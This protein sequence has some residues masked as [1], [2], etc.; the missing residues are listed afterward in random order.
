MTEREMTEYVN[1]VSKLVRLSISD[2]I[3]S[4]VMA[5]PFEGTLEEAQREGVTYL[6]YGY[7]RLGARLLPVKVTVQAARSGVTMEIS[8]KSGNLRFKHRY[9]SKMAREA[10]VEAA[11]EALRLCLN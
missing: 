5:L 3:R 10:C 9:D 7:I 1:I 11:K 4:L 8:S 2:D 6:A